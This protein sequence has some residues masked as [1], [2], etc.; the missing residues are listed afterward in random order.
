MR[1]IP[2]QYIFLTAAIERLKNDR[3]DLIDSKTGRVASCFTGDTT[4]NEV[5]TTIAIAKENVTLGQ[6][7]DV[8]KSAEI[9]TDISDEEVGI[10]TEF[11]LL[12]TTK[13]NRVREMTGVLLEEK[14]GIEHSTQKLYFPISSKLGQ[15]VLGRRVG[16]EFTYEAENGMIHA[17]TIT[18][19]RKSM[20]IQEDKQSIKRK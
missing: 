18:A 2:E 15:A 12:V 14:L 17:A 1:L 20:G 19:L 6:L 9:I 7:L 16:E 11:D 10:G 13:R 3:A 4:D 5:E 8:L